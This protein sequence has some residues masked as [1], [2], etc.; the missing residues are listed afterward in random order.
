MTALSGKVVAITGAA[1][2]LGSALAYACAKKGARLALAD[3]NAPVLAEVA[4]LLRKSGAHVSHHPTDVSK[5]DEVRRFAEEASATHGGVDVVM[6]NAGIA[7]KATIEQATYD[8]LEAVLGV[9]LWGALYTVKEFLPS[10]RARSGGHIVLVS[11]I[12]AMVPFAHNG[13]Y[14]IAKSAVSALAETLYEELLDTNIRVT[15]VHPGGVRTNIF[16]STRNFA[17]RDVRRFERVALTSSTR[18]ASAIVGAVEADRFRLFVGLDAHVMARARWLMP[19]STLRL[20]S[21]F[22]RNG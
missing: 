19:M 1:S 21:H 3:I 2:G 8:D 22:T 18:A 17:R 13:I 5:R 14:N 15:C 16:R 20:A 12:T 6:A 10:L 9:N 11:S 4:D 7:S